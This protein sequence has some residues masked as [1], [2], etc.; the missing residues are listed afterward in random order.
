MSRTLRILM[1]E[2]NPLDAELNEYALR[3]AGIQFEFVRVV[4]REDYEI[5][6]IDFDPDVILSDYELLSFDGIAAMIIAKART[7]DVPFIFVTGVMGEQ[8]AIDTLKRG[9]TDYVL[10]NRLSR[11]ATAVNR[12]LDEVVEKTE[13]KRAEEGLRESERRYR[14]VF[15]STGTAM[16][17]IDANATISFANKQF[18]RMFGF[19]PG[20]VEGR[21]IFGL[22]TPSPEVLKEF[23]QKYAEV[24]QREGS[25]VDF[26]SRVIGAHNEDLIVLT[27]MVV[28]P[29]TDNLAVSLIDITLEKEY[30]SELA[31]RAERLEHFMTIASHELRHPVTIIKGYT[32]IL[33]KRPEDFTSQNVTNI[34]ETLEHAADR[35]TSIIDELMDVSR[36]ET[37]ELLHDK[38]EA[39]IELLVNI[40]VDRIDTMGFDNQVNVSMGTDA[41]YAVV[42]AEKMVQ[43]LIILLENAAYYSPDHSAI[44]VKIAN[45]DGEIII[46]IMDHGPGIQPEHRDKIFE[47]FYQVTDAMHHSTPGLGLGLYIARKIANAHGGDVTYSPREGGGSVFSISIPLRAD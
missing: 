8:M 2:D 46:S 14:A 31:K 7:P 43:L 17:V 44:D 18:E 45:A 29:G 11:L 39:D 19:G 9:A 30:E 4:T 12:A 38:R 42:D 28:L 34:Y 26:E 40:A 27:T 47:R 36:F 35:L 20:E 25:P 3:K 21:D 32:T 6:L 37:L 23:K 5:A 10:K 41:G 24:L 15:E 33:T 13:R 22:L 16:C 1:L